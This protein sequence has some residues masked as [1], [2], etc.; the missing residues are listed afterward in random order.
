[1]LEM[2]TKTVGRSAKAKS[3][4][5][6][7]SKRCKCYGSGISGGLKGNSSTVLSE[8][9][10]CHAL[11]LKHACDVYLKVPPNRGCP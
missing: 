10:C 2:A 9:S 5:C 1:M 8:R 6:K 3:A 11:F 7:E 4:L